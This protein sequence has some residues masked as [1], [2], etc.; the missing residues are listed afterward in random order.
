MHRSDASAGC[1]TV[2]T[3][4]ALVPGIKGIWVGQ[5]ATFGTFYES[6]VG[7]FM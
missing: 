4:D 6:K 1:D 5:K 2:S 7:H 3:S